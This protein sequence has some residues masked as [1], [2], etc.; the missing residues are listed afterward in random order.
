M[1]GDFL[2]DDLPIFFSTE[3]FAETVSRYDGVTF[4][5]HFYREWQ[6]DLGVEAYVA[7]LLCKTA[8]VADLKGGDRVCVAG[9]WYRISGA[10]RAGESGITE[11]DLK[12]YV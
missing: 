9:T 5:A 1:P 8:D 10:K 2:I 7:T 11:L 4:D 12:E 3:E 6:P